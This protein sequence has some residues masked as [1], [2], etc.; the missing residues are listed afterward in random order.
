MNTYLV[1]LTN[2][3]LVKIGK[4]KSIK[5]R[6]NQIKVCNPFVK[7]F[8][9]LEGDYEKY[10]HYVFHDFRET[11][12]WFNFEKLTKEEILEV[13]TVAVE[14]RKNYIDEIDKCKNSND[15]NAA[16]ILL[17]KDIRV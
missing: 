5:A 13:V 14:H 11:G 8:D 12:E 7:S 17:K 4:S 9:Y 3:G 15:F 6:R 2:S 10:L 16:M 1:T